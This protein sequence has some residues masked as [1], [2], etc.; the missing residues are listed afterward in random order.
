MGRTRRE[1]QLGDTV[2]LRDC[3]SVRP[4]LRGL[5]GVVVDKWGPVLVGPATTVGHKQKA[6]FKYRV[7]TSDKEVT[8]VDGHDGLRLEKEEAAS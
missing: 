6:C 8:I 3:F 2:K 4:H 1:F 7:Q 5:S